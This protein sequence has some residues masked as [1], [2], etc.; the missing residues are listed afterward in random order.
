MEEQQVILKIFRALAEEEEEEV[1]LTHGDSE[2]TCDMKISDD[3]GFEETL[4]ER[5]ALSWLLLPPA[6]EKFFC[7]SEEVEKGPKVTNE[8]RRTAGNSCESFGTERE[9]NKQNE[10]RNAAGDCEPE[11]VGCRR[12]CPDCVCAAA[13]KQ[14]DDDA[15]GEAEH[16][17][18]GESEQSDVGFGAKDASKSSSSS[19]ERLNTVAHTGPEAGEQHGAT[20][21]PTLEQSDEH[22]YFRN[23]NEE[24]SDAE[25]EGKNK[26]IKVF[27][28]QLS[29]PKQAPLNIFPSDMAR[30]PPPG[31]TISR[32]TYSPGSPTEK[33]IQLPALFSGLRVLRKGVLGPEQESVAP[34]RPSPQRSDREILPGKGGEAKGSILEQISNFLSRERRDEEEEKEEDGER[35]Q[36]QSEEDADTPS[37]PLKPVSSAEA[38]FDAFKAFFTPKPLKRDPGEKM[39]LEAV[40]KRI[41]AERDALRALFEGTSVKSSEQKEPSDHQVGVTCYGRQHTFN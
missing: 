29:S 24:R 38:A 2:I 41:K 34:L 5:S 11:Q 27:P 26:E 19:A 15:A 9:L 16:S 18:R 12:R 8:E 25:E 3:R 22:F 31:S 13:L 21:K 7:D 32:A 30:N 4:T 10:R 36:V 6:G 33:H 35:R 14:D 1:Y 40:R 39:D 23:A 28:Y 37:E 20:G 17:L